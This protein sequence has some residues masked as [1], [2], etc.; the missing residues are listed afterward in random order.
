MRGYDDS[1]EESAEMLQIIGQINLNKKDTIR[2]NKK[3]EGVDI[4]SVGSS[5]NLEKLRQS[6]RRIGREKDSSILVKVSSLCIA[7]CAIPPL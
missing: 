7:C 3:K 2:K 6:G 4:D 1:G 5:Y